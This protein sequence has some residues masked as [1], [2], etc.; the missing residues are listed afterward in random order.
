VKTARLLA[1]G[2]VAAI[3]VIQPIPARSAETYPTECRNGSATYAA[4]VGKSET[5]SP[6]DFDLDKLAKAER[7]FA[8]CATSGADTEDVL[9]GL[10]GVMLVRI[11]RGRLGEMQ[12][13]YINVL[14]APVSQRKS[15]FT[16]ARA[17]A[18][19]NYQSALSFAQ[20][21][22][23]HASQGR[24]DWSIFLRET[25]WLVDA[26]KDVSALDFDHLQSRLALLQGKSKMRARPPAEEAGLHDLAKPPASSTTD[27]LTLRERKNPPATP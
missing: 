14:T 17:Y 26:I 27:P 6:N 13:R 8:T 2:L 3:V 10:H 24:S 25:A 9:Y 5:T 4:A 21:A 16:R 20:D 18:L 22:M 12:A 15:T 19:D 1:C 11:A 7:E 23:N